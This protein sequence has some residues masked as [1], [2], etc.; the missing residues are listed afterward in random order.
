[1]SSILTRIT[2]MRMSRRRRRT[3]ARQGAAWLPGSF[4][5]AVCT[6]AGGIRIPSPRAS[7]E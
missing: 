7:D 3:A 2:A 6:G 4:A 1:M 5:D